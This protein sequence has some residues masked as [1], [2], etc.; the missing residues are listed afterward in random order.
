MLTSRVVLAVSDLFKRA[1][2]GFWILCVSFNL[3]Y[4]LGAYVQLYY[5]GG[6]SRAVKY[7]NL[8]DFAQDSGRWVLPLLVLVLYGTQKPMALFSAGTVP[9]TDQAN[10][11]GRHK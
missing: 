6:Y 4:V 2:L 8:I 11:T 3:S 1:K 10:A 5:E 9:G 7:T